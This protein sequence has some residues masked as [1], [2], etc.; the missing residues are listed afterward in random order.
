MSPPGDFTLSLRVAWWPRGVAD[1]KQVATACGGGTA[2]RGRFVQR[3]TWMGVAYVTETL[4]R[5][6]EGGVMQLAVIAR[7]ERLGT[8]RA[9]FKEWARRV[10][11]R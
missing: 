10:L 1:A 5:S 7:S 9:I 6:V 11:L 8:A 4:V 2:D 3:T